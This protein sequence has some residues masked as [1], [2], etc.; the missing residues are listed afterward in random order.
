MLHGWRDATLRR[1]E[2]AL[3]P[4]PFFLQRALHRF[5]YSLKY[6]RPDEMVEDS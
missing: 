6:H 3:S 2:L 1:S 5:T 4:S